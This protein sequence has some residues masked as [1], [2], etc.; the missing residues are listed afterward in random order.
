MST[1]HVV[2]HMKQ[3]CHDYD[4]RAITRVACSKSPDMQVHDNCNRELPYSMPYICIT[5]PTGVKMAAGNH[6]LKLS[7]QMANC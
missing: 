5:R 1:T 4:I 6:Q 3:D 2:N 7:N